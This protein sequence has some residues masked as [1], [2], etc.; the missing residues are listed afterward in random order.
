MVIA[1][2]FVLL[3]AAQ[4]PVFPAQVQ[5]VGVTISATDTRTGAPVS[6]LKPE[7]F[8]V[9]ENG[10]RQEIQR[11]LIRPTDH[12]SALQAPDNGPA[13]FPIGTEHTCQS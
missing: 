7:D 13:R 3:Q 10:K 1:T 5:G 12:V 8:A 6:D 9:L 2:L 11:P 4:A